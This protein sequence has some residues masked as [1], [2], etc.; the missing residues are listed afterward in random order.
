MNVVAPSGSANGLSETGRRKGGGLINGIYW[1]TVLPETSKLVPALKK[2]TRNA[3]VTLTPKF[4]TKGAKSAGQTAGRDLQSGV[5]S[6]T[7][8]SS[9]GRLFRMDGARAAGARAGGDINSGLQSANIGRGVMSSIGSNMMAGATSLGRNIGSMIASGLKV[10]AAVGGTTLIAGL[11]MALNQGF[12]R[13][14][15][16]DDARFKLRGLGNDA[17]AVQNIMDNALAAVKGTAFGLDEA[18]TTAA[19]AVAAGIQPGEQLTGYLKLTADTAAIAGTSLAEMGSIFNSVQTSG[20]AFTGDLRMLSDRGLP[21]F[22]WLQDEYKVTGEEL[23]DMVADG[24]VDS[25]T[26]QRVIAQNIGGAAQEMG[27]SVRGS[28]SNLKAS[29]SRFGAELSGPI[30]AALQPLAIGLTGVFDK[31]TAAIKPVMA[32]LTAK[33]GPWATDM[34]AKMKAWADNGGIERVIGFFE[35]LVAQVKALTTGQGRNDAMASI[36]ESARQLGPALQQAGPALEGVGQSAKAFGQAMLDIGPQTLSAVL[37]PALKILAGALKF[38]AD[39]ASWAVPAITGLVLAFMGFRA[40]GQTLGPVVAMINGA[41]KIINAP[42]ILA[43]T[44]AISAQAAA[45]NRLTAALGANTVAATTNTTAQ[46]A[47]AAMGLR[48]RAAAMASAVASRVA[49][50]AQWLWNAA[51]AANPIGLIVAAVVA[52]GVAIWAF[53][54]KTEVGRKL[55]DKIWTGIKTTA[56][57]VWKWLKETLGKAWEQLGPGLKQLGT[58]ASQA[59]AALSDAVKKVWTAIQP[60][61]TWLAKLWLQIQKFNFT[62]AIAALK[63]LGATIG[64]LWTNVVVPA[65]NNIVAVISTWWN[66]T[67]TIWSAAT[68]AIGWVG[69]KIMWLWNAVAVPAFNAIKTVVLAFWEAAKGVWDKFTGAIDLVSQKV[70]LFKDAFVT[71]FNAV[72]D[73]VTNVWNAISGIIDKIGNGVSTVADVLRNIPGIGALIPGHANGRPPGF[74]SGR[75]ATLSRS[76]QLS[77]PGTGTSDSILALLSNGEGVVKESSM[78]GGGGLVVAALNAGWVPSPEF[79]HGMLPGF[80]EGLNP[81]ADWLR[82]TIMRTFPA[83]TSI[84]GKRS[85]DGYGEHSSGNAIDVMIPGYSTAEGKAM[86]DQIASWIKQNRE[87][88]GVDGM[89]WRQT[90]FGYGSDWSA[91]KVMGD[92]GSD[93][94]NHMDHLH[95]ILGKGRGAGAASVDMPA[96]SVQLA[97]SLGGGGGGST[98][99]SLGSST[100]ASGGGGT[101]RAATDSELSASSKRVDSANTAVKNAQQSVDD[102]QYAVDRAQKRV[103]ELRAEGKDTADAEHSLQV[104]NREHADAME[105]LTKAREKAA[106]VQDA[107]NALRSQ[108]VEEAS[109]SSSSSESGGGFGDLGKSLWGGLL[110]TIGLDGSVF[111]NP[112][113]WPT[114][115]SL[116][117]GANYVGSLLKGGDSAGVTPGGGTGDGGGIGGLLGGLTDAI[118]VGGLLPGGLNPGANVAAPHMGSGAAPGGTGAAARA[119][120]SAGGEKPWIDMRG[121]QLGVSPQDMFNKVRVEQNH[122]TRTT[123]KH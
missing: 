7:R 31:V 19:S 22:Q 27:G 65:F 10:T 34:A 100:S 90:S 24:K 52:A 17:G 88:L 120:E 5:E 26:F 4:D 36:A 16:I 103:D 58:M 112:F 117:A 3:D 98:A 123:V 106:E 110:E 87:A 114:V 28:L 18:A 74:A 85:E 21:V 82:S 60:A 2:A 107:D 102:R 115:K 12:S 47:N 91:G 9:F 122:R 32:E 97:S 109:K 101:F 111:E 57:A 84:G 66:N 71:G 78:R 62:V 99:S 92:R 51:L 20:K 86:G 72:K 67:Q 49:A 35:R 73:V 118:G 93:T 108:G 33:V 121:A 41:L 29:F 95:V 15:A 44:A 14:T 1:L 43:Q 70:G 116:M 38:V 11:G 54:T 13:L 75:P 42:I 83:I 105:R 89:I 94:Q 63:A 6:Q 61:V 77:G 48:A 104:A 53:F 23:A 45:M 81:G 113:E 25:A 76:G 119:A 80:A 59:F 8:G 69:D 96:D 39:N 40:V 46:G 30:F 56:A 37:V 50:T 64:W 68:T 79:L 55:W